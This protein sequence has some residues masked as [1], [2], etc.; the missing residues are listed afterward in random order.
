MTAL[1]L[2][3]DSRSALAAVRSLGSHGVPAW[4]A[5][6]GGESLAGHSRHARG[7]HRLPSP[8]D[9]PGEYPEAVHKL[10]TALGVAVVMPMTDASVMLLTRP[11]AEPA[12]ETGPRIAAPAR[13]AYLALS[14]K[15]EL[16]TRAQALGIPVP[17]TIIARTPAELR[18]AAA[19]LGFPCVLKPARS[20]L[21]DQGHIIGTHVRI[22][23]DAA[24]VDTVAESRW[25][26]SVPCLV[27]AFIPGRGAGVFALCDGEQP[28]AWFAHRR[29]REKP[30]AGGVSVLCESIAP[31]PALK[32][33][34]AKLLRATPMLGPAM[35]E[36]RM[37]ESGQPWLMEVNA[38]FWG[39][40]QLAVDAGVDFPWLLYRL[41]LGE[42][43]SGPE[44]YAEGLKL[45]WELGDLDHLLL[46]LRG[47]GTARGAGARLA[48]LLRYLGLAGPRGRGEV[49][50]RDDRAPFRYELRTWFST[51]GRA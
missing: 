34:S 28:V 4:V 10:A 42:T 2:D 48:A 46:Q 51:L 11:G 22:A 6:S 26:R 33:L 32:A 17:R 31:D 12:P 47:R 37:D 16:V 21:L 40:L 39:S 44:H 25:F 5:D 27:Q 15:A 13:E 36:Y 30:P 41:C 49:H 50:R 19:E 1:V 45:R 7:H 24:A 23:Q 43:V 3:A 20:R 18:A 9:A 38:R 14:D 35:V 8:L 29:L